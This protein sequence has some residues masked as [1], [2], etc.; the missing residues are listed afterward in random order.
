MA[1]YLKDS[2]IGAVAYNIGHSYFSPI[3]LMFLSRYLESSIWVAISIIW[4]AHIAADR[5]LG[6]DL[7]LSTGF[8]DTHLGRL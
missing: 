3:I 8:K 2:K 6:F 4:A 1:G 7:K 5:I